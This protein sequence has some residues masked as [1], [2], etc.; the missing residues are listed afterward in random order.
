MF[1]RKS[2]TRCVSRAVRPTVEAMEGRQ[3][4]SGI[5]TTYTLKDLGSAPPANYVAYNAEGESAV[6]H[7]IGETAIDHVFVNDKNGVTT[8]IGAPPVPSEYGVDVEAINNKGQILVNTGTITV[9]SSTFAESFIYDPTS[10]T[11]TGIGNFPG[12]SNQTRGLGLNDLGQVVG[13]YFP[14]PYVQDGFI[15]SNGTFTDITLPEIGNSGHILAEPSSTSVS[16][17]VAGVGIDND[18]S[19]KVGQ[20]VEF[21]YK[22]GNAKYVDDLIRVGSGFKATA[23][24]GYTNVERVLPR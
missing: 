12:T 1:F 8:D 21:I 13:Y 7:T 5:A 14:T 15:Y 4:L 20:A 10:K 9:D 17:M 19:F 2:K 11:W 22:D 6:A 23:N 24:G 3:L 16:G 18:P